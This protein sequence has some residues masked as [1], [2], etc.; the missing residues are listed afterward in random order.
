MRRTA[1][2]LRQRAIVFNAPPTARIMR[3]MTRPLRSVGLTP[4]S[5]PAE[6]AAAREDQAGQSGTG[7]GA[8]DAQVSQTDTINH[9]IK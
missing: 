8:G 6:K 4:P 7:D 1:P 5:P 9:E 2:S 3:A